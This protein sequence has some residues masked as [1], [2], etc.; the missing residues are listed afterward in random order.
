MFYVKYFTFMI[1]M[2]SRR[3]VMAG[4]GPWQRWRSGPRSEG[5]GGRRVWRG[6]RCGVRRG[7]HRGSGRGANATATRAP[8]RRRQVK[9]TTAHLYN[10][11]ILTL[12]TALF[13]HFFIYLKS[14]GEQRLKGIYRRERIHSVCYLLSKITYTKM[15]SKY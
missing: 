10:S 12:N 1:E 2:M 7:R 4:G 8:R 13:F 6:G 15:H 9:R 3:W 14:G 11:N 5:R